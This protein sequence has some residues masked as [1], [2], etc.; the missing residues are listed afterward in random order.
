MSSRR[1]EV[2]SRVSG[3]RRWTVEQKLTILRDAFGPEGC[4]RTACERHDVGSGSIY[5]WRALPAAG[6]TSLFRSDSAARSTCGGPILRSAQAMGSAWSA[7]AFARAFANSASASVARWVIETTSALSASTSFGKGET[8]AFMA[9]MN[10]HLPPVQ[11]ENVA[12]AEKSGTANR[13]A[14]AQRK[15][16]AAG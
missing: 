9:E 4:M 6:V 16:G 8:A 13:K 5:I 10:Q 15:T 12:P 2:V 11:P 7:E 14:E 1:I 3:R